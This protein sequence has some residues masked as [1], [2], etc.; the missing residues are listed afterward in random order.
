MIES[1]ARDGQRPVVKI[2]NTGIIDNEACGQNITAAD[3]QRAAGGDFQNLVDFEVLMRADV[4][5]VAEFLVRFDVQFVCEMHGSV[6]PREGAFIAVEIFRGDRPA[7]ED[8]GAVVPSFDAG[9]FEG[10]AVSHGDCRTA[11]G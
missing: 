2:K 6:G 5:R 3:R 4:D 7:I 11:A 9:R 10:T 1:S 8:D